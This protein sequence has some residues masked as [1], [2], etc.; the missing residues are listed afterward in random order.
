MGD[1][2]ESQVTTLPQ[3]IAN[4]NRFADRVEHHFRYLDTEGADN[5]EVERPW[6]RLDRLKRAFKLAGE[7]IE[8]SCKAEKAEKRPMHCL[9]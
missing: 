5:G 2:R 6:S 4:H 8:D 3:W 7:D 1:K 9:F